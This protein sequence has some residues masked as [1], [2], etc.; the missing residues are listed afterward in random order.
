MIKIL[1]I[2]RTIWNLEQV[3]L[4]I[5][6]TIIKNKPVLLDLNGEGPDL[7][8]I[9]L[10]QLLD[11][12]CNDYNFPKKLI[13]IKTAN[14]LES[15]VEYQIQHVH[16]QYELD[17]TRKLVGRVDNSKQFNSDFKYFGH[18]IGH[19]NRYRLELASY[20]YIN[21]KKQTLQTY[22]SDPRIP[23]HR[24]HLGLEEFLSAG[25]TAEEFNNAKELLLNSP[26]TLD[27]APCT[28]TISVPENLGI[29]D[30]YPNFFVELV[31][32]SFFSGKTFY[33]DEKIWRPILM[34]TP[35]IVQSSQNFLPNLRRLGFRTFGN[36][37]DEG[38][39]EDPADCQ[40]SVIKTNIDRLS[41]LDMLQLQSMYVDM[42]PILEHNYNRLLELKPKEFN[43]IFK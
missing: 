21:Y 39:S 22:H 1:S 11:R 33:V 18:F 12:I 13:T 26:I 6:A 40:T 9:G 31:N 35:F 16:Q 28:E 3:A 20:L 43:E 27:I 23:Y 15:H 30:W 4:D 41:K 14:F 2:D 5:V 25:A 37:W 10:Y 34:R 7:T 29:V 17:G 19:S 42:Q 36:Y 24:E 8:H 38:Y 32:M